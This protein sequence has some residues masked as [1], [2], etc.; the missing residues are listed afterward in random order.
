MTVVV[1]QKT[2]RRGP[3]PLSSS[4]SM[5]NVDVPILSGTKTKART[6]TNSAKQLVLASE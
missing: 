4:R 3:L 2:H 1:R 5:P 6:V